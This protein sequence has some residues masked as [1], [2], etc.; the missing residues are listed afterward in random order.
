MALN[1][2]LLIS[3]C[4]LFL[5]SLYKASISASD[6]SWRWVGPSV[7][8]DVSFAQIV[9]ADVFAPAVFET[10]V[11][12]EPS[13]TRISMKPTD[14]LHHETFFQASPP[15]IPPNVARSSSNKRILKAC[16]LPVI[17]SV[18]SA[19]V[20]LRCIPCCVLPFSGSSSRTLFLALILAVTVA[21]TLGL[22]V[23]QSLLSASNST[24]FDVLRIVL[25]AHVGMAGIYVIVSA[26]WDTLERCVANEESG[27]GQGEVAAEEDTLGGDDGEQ[28][29][30]SLPVSNLQASTNMASLPSKNLARSHS[31]MYM[32]M[33]SSDHVSQD[34]FSS[35]HSAIFRTPLDKLR[36]DVAEY[37]KDLDTLLVTDLFM[38]PRKVPSTIAS[39]PTVVHEPEQSVANMFA[40]RP[41]PFPDRPTNP[42]PTGLIPNPMLQDSYPQMD[43]ITGTPV[44]LPSLLPN[45]S[46][47]LGNKGQ[48]VMAQPLE[49][50]SNP[51]LR[52]TY[53][54]TLSAEGGNFRRPGSDDW[55]IPRPEADVLSDSDPQDGAATGEGF[56]A[57]RPLAASKPANRHPLP[58]P[59]HCA[60]YAPA[61]QKG[62]CRPPSTSLLPKILDELATMIH[63][64]TLEMTR[65]STKENTQY[66]VATLGFFR[67]DQR[68][69]GV[70]GLCPSSVPGIRGT[71]E[72]VWS[73]G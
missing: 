43:P 34:L 55:T 52:S 49:R 23:V 4:L 60:Y 40:A 38:N 35:F 27:I 47:Q 28:D 25:F 44:P 63:R 11:P 45:V 72:T 66:Y 62:N 17:M 26:L 7:L 29:I 5:V 12:A 6:V 56:T 65:I 22:L 19:I 70:D 2:A 20:V 14:Y 15:G 51:V 41:F 1:S 16:S 33:E 67:D 18:L 57:I 13:S 30:G 48:G 24:T 31:T 61:G 73:T 21:L 71:L 68:C 39:A 58:F 53:E 46:Q 50:P 8:M 64:R 3:V 54:G 59:L 37:E 10:M 9:V 36:R 69:I 42:C 32:S